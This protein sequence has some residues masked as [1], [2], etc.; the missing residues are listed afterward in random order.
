MRS[1]NRRSCSSEPDPFRPSDPRQFI[2]TSLAR[3]KLSCE[4][5]PH[6]II[7]DVALQVGTPRFPPASTFSS[8]FPFLFIR[9]RSHQR[10]RS[11]CNKEAS[12]ATC[13]NQRGYNVLRISNMYL[14][15]SILR[16]CT[17][18]S[19]REARRRRRLMNSPLSLLPGPSHDD[20]GRGNAAVCVLYPKAPLR[21]SVI[22]DLALAM[23]KDVSQRQKL[24]RQVHAIYACFP[25]PQKRAAPRTPRPVKFDQQPLNRQPGDYLFA[26]S[27][28]A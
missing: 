23:L 1:T 22:L 3:S 14:W 25:L 8:S 6:L 27:T 11:S 7:P 18:R 24:S 9:R 2:I 19:I 20:H 12:T 28:A 17:T 4:L 5:I 16:M 13:M 21:R 26:L 10:H 15:L